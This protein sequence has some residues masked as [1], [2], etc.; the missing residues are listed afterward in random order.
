MGFGWSK[1]GVTE[2]NLQSITTPFQPIVNK[3]YILALLAD[4]FDD[5]R[6]QIYSTVSR[7]DP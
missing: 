4:E 1:T 6:R 3:E 5:L 7:Y 2:E